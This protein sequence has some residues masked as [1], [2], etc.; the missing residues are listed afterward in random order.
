VNAAVSLAASATEDVRHLS[1]SDEP[2]VT[3]RGDDWLGRIPTIAVTYLAKLSFPP[4]GALGIT[5]AVPLIFLASILG[6][7]SGRMHLAVRRFLFF[8][9]LMSVLWGIQLLRG[10]PFSVGSLM[11]MTVLHLP[12]VLYVPRSADQYDEALRYFQTTATFIAGMG[13]VQYV[14]QFVAT[15]AIAYPIENFLPPQFLVSGFNMQGWLEYGSKIFRANG[16]FMLEPSFFSQLL[17]LGIL[18]EL[19]KFHRPKYLVILSLGLIL[20]YS[21]SGLLVLAI[22]LPFVLIRSGRWGLLLG[23][24]VLAVVGMVIVGMVGETSWFDIFL[25]RSGEFTSKGSS[26][27]ARY[28]GGFYLFEQFLWPDPMRALFG[29]G[30]GS[31]QGYVDRANFF[32]AATTLFKIVFEYGIVGA[33]AYFAFLFHCVAQSRAPGVIRLAVGF[34]FMLSG[35][36]IAFAHGLALALLIWNSP[37]TADAALLRGG[38]RLKYR[39]ANRPPEPAAALIEARP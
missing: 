37:D 9:L 20:S 1:E 25:K 34:I 4:L 15:P 39:G 10:E 13:I 3:R 14:L 21:G 27:F 32:A 31:F 19:L 22:G 17:A 8:V 11:L 5:V 18:V 16:V 38:R 23:A 6:V 33:V 35:I 12:Y 29:F 7:V 24:V 28:V 30:A 2:Q 36:H 26:G